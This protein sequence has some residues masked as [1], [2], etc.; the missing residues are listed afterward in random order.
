M[1]RERERERVGTAHSSVE[2]LQ[3]GPATVIKSGGT[4]GS[5]VRSQ[6]GPTTTTSNNRAGNRC[7]VRVANF[8]SSCQRFGIQFFLLNLIFYVTVFVNRIGGN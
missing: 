5:T 3:S 4:T 7:Y 1:E 8:F 2:A 6:P